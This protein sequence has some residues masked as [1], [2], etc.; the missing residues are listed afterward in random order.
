V[1]TG[2]NFE[3]QSS[4]NTNNNTNTISTKDLRFR[5]SNNLQSSQSGDLR[6]KLT[7]QEKDTNVAKKHSKTSKIKSNKK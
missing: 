4:I 6:A 3:D 5:L 1:K 7:N 2:N